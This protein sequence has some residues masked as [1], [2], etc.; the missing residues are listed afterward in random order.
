[1][2]VLGLGAVV[3]GEDVAQRAPLW[4]TDQRAALAGIA[5]QE[6]ELSGVGDKPP[7]QPLSIGFVALGELPCI[8]G[9]G[10]LGARRPIAS[11]M[12]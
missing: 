2:C 9:H 5:D 1:M 3:V 12:R 8:P 7:G 10:T 11:R 4:G 6:V